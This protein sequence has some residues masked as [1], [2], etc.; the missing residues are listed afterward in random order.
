[1]LIKK[2]SDLTYADVTPLSVYLNRRQFL[3][4]AG[5]AAGAAVLG[6]EIGELV[7]PGKSVLAASSFP[8]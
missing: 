8:N 7:L 4:G 2:E 6:N 5:L 3:Y 1:M